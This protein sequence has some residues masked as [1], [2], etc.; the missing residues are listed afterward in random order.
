MP[1]VGKPLTITAL[2]K[3]VYA[4]P[5][6]SVPPLEEQEQKV[7]LKTCWELVAILD[8]LSIFQAYL[9][10]Q[11]LNFSAEELESCLVLNNGT[12]GLLPEIHM[13]SSWHSAVALHWIILS[14]EIANKLT[15]FAI[16]ICQLIAG[17]SNCKYSANI[18]PALS[19]SPAETKYQRSLANYNGS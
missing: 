4:V 12:S 6:R 14:Q 10:L 16:R 5:E 13:V 3:C 18:P 11:H 15:A 17:Q 2:M 19:A 7:K 1:Y 8:F 9:N